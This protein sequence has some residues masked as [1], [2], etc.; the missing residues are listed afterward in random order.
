MQTPKTTP[1]DKIYPMSNR[2][3]F[4][5][6]LQKEMSKRNWTQADF[7]RKSGL[8]RAIISKLI[9]G[10]ST[11]LPDTLLAIAIALKLPEA[12]VFE[13]AGIL[14]TNKDT[15]P[16]VEQMNV[17]L[18]SIKD[19]AS[20]ALAERVLESLISGPSEAPVRPTAKKAK[21]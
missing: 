21:A 8:H 12:Q 2:E 5:A 13:A 16:W 6:W 14:P 15:D 7:S 1:R 4:A 3:K 10:A 9:L 20:R 18:N 11:P 17:K 19:P